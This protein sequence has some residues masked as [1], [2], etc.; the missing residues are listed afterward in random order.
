M[1]AHAHV[2]PE[3]VEAPEPRPVE[4]L[5]HRL[6][7]LSL[8]EPEPGSACPACHESLRLVAFCGACGWREA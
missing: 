2:R 5:P 8:E 3:P 1:T 6:R 7:G 4:A